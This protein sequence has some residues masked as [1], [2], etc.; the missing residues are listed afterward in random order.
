MTLKTKVKV[1]QG[2]SWLI[3]LNYSVMVT[4]RDII[5]NATIGKVTM[6]NPMGMSDVLE[7]EGQII[8]GQNWLNIVAYLWNGSR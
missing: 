6:S 4:D 1:I 7:N 2:H 5:S 8:K 3:F